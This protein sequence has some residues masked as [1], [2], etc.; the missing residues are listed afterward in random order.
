VSELAIGPDADPVSDRRSRVRE[1]F[2]RLL[3]ADAVQLGY[4]RWKSGAQPPPTVL[5][6][7]SENQVS[8]CL[9]IAAESGWS[10]V[11]AGVG[12]W[13]GAGNSVRSPDAILSVSRLDRIVQY[14]PADLTLTAGAG[15]SLG[16]VD[17][18]ASEQGQW[19]PLDPPGLE[20][21]TL[22][23]TLVTASAGGLAMAYGAPRDLVLGLRVV[24]GDGRALRLGGRVVKNVAGFDLVKL[25]V[26]SW[27]TLGV[28][29]EATFRLFPRPQQELCLV[30]RCERLEDLLDGARRVAHAR[31]LPAALELLERPAAEGHREA[32]LVVRLVG[33]EERVAREAALLEAALAPLEV[34]RVDGRS[35][36]GAEL[37][38]AIRHVEEDADLTLRF[39][40]PVAHLAELLTVARAAGRLRPGHDE[41][42]SAP[43]RVAVDGLRGS[44][45][46]V[47]PRVRVDP[48]WAERWAARTLE[49]RANAEFRDGSLTIAKGPAAVVDGCGTWG[50]S[51]GTARLM[52]GLKAQFDPG[53]ILSPGR[54]SFEED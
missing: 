47:I 46:L 54:L 1:A 35:G 29:T 36:E 42:T 37:V 49:L 24:T 44:L 45:R 17:G 15:L 39:V 41:L 20:E 26:G 32:L 51:G 30:S 43:Y 31:I 22:G 38:S 10:I 34:A 9:R 23:A 19:L 8:E 16:G 5:T 33:L 53:G 18:V 50:K 28:I 14:E 40:G 6:P 7:S 3:G 48:P 27:G 52:A 2:Q 13:L 25:L 4:G 12:S 11:P 21:G